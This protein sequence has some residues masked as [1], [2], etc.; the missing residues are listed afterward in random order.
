M[1]LLAIL[2]CVACGTSKKKENPVMDKPDSTGM[3]TDTVAT[4]PANSSMTGLTANAA[5]VNELLRTKKGPGW[6]LLN[7][8]DTR[9]D[10]F[11][12]YQKEVSAKRK[13]NPDFPF[14]V[15]SD[16]NGDGQPDYV[17]LVTDGTKEGEKEFVHA[18]TRIAILPGGG[19]VI[20]SNE[21]CFQHTLLKIVPKSTTIEGY[22]DKDKKIK[23]TKDAIDVNN[24]DGGGY[25][26][27]WDGKKFAYLYSEG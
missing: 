20:I 26:I 6:R 5:A 18:A 22:D 9:V 24:W 7:D 10:I 2:G 14:L 21:N 16:F 8:S 12:S 25:Y 3:N 1:I 27:Y 13:D 15:R 4:P 11:E 19:D 23:L 17:A